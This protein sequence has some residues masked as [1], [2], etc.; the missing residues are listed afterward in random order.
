[1]CEAEL[2]LFVNRDS[3]ERCCLLQRLKVS[4]GTHSGASFE[5]VRAESVAHFSKSRE[6]S[7]FEQEELWCDNV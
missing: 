7:S 2:E 5:V 3:V 4:V 1:M 6:T